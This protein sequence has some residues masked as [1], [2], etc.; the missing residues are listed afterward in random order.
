MDY[1]LSFTKN[2][3]QPQNRQVCLTMPVFSHTVRLRNHPARLKLVLADSA[4]PSIWEQSVAAILV[5]PPID[6]YL[7]AQ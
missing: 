4:L 7:F 2:R 6:E 3:D 5:I 1:V